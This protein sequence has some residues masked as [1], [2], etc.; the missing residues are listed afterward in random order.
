LPFIIKNGHQKDVDEQHGFSRFDYWR[1][2]I[3]NEYVQLAC[4][5]HPDKSIAEFDG[6]IR[7][8]I[9]LGD[10]EFSEV[11]ANPQIA[12]RT[13][14]QINKSGENDFLISFQMEKS[15]IVRQYGREALLTPGS[16]A[17]YDST[18]PYSLSFDEAFHQFVIKMPR[19][20]LARHLIEPEK[21]SA[22]SMNANSGL[23][24][25]LKDFIFSL[26]GELG[27]P[28]SETSELLSENLVNLI[29]LSFSSTVFQ[30]NLA[31]SDCVKEALLRR[32]RGF[33]AN[34][35]LDPKLNNS[36]IAESQG[37]SVRYLHKLFQSQEESIHEMILN[38]RLA[39]AHEL[40]LGS[41]E[42]K[43]TVESVAYHVGFSGAPHF[44]RAFKLRY[45]VCPSSI[46]A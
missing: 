34:N 9:G 14:E 33:I 10:V 17:L 43:P 16:F 40:L 27:S 45:G 24:L 1:E 44:S 37:I 19:E 23:G 36:C 35:L 13:S 21:Y 5:P 28:E 31:E 41:D 20:V 11:V 4:D 39:I 3:S 30:N 22:I 15:C 29:A 2:M 8:G 42:S 7:A 26:V 18:A 6:A 25:V 32:I 46:T 12:K 38:K